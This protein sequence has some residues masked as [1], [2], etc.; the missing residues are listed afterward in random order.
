MPI[1]FFIIQAEKELLRQL[2]IGEFMPRMFDSMGQV[3]DSEYL[4]L[5]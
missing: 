5:Q 2:W 3:D 4:L 1:Q